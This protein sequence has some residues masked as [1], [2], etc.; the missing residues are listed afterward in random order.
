[1][2]ERLRAAL[3]FALQQLLIAASG[4]AMLWLIR[5]FTGH[6]V[7]GA[8][9][10]VGFVEALAILVVYGLHLLI[11][12]GLFRR[13][14]ADRSLGLAPSG[15]GLRDCVLGF[16]VALLLY[17]GPW[18][19][20]LAVGD[21]RITDT[22]AAHAA[23][24]SAVQVGFWVLA[25]L[26]N[27]V[28]EEATCRAFPM[29]LW[30]RERL[31]FRVLVPALAFAAFHLIDEP[32]D[33]GAF[34][35]RSSA[36]V[37]FGL[38]Y[39]TTG[40]AWLAVGLHTGLNYAS[41]ARS[42]LWHAGAWARVE[43]VPVVP[44]EVSTLAAIAIVGWIFVARN[45]LRRPETAGGGTGDPPEVPIETAQVVEAGR[46]RRRRDGSASQELRRG[47]E[48]PHR[49]AVLQRGQPKVSL[50]SAG[51][52]CVGHSSGGGEIGDRSL[53]C[54]ASVE[55]P[56]HAAAGR[57]RPSAAGDRLAL[58]RGRQHPADIRHRARRIG[59]VGGAAED[60][61]HLGVDGRMRV[62]EKN[63]TRLVGSNER[64]LDERARRHVEPIAPPGRRD[65]PPPD[66]ELDGATRGLRQ[67]EQPKRPCH[68]DR[69]SRGVESMHTVTR[70]EVRVE[71]AKAPAAVRRL[72]LHG[73]PPAR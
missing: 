35:F 69:R 66:R 39:A 59:R 73:Q 27:S 11:T 9:D 47:Y 50:E 37:L 29:Q 15:R 64:G 65:A 56:L 58:G 46:S 71:D 40:N 16:G 4:F 60:E 36:G 7:H 63:A 14:A 70:D 19:A 41:I 25:L 33:G 24:I 54:E 26:V 21:A 13:A 52:R 8:A 51:H 67:R 61:G 1:M 10:E 62:G 42:G 12:V 43:G 22:L 3:L 28:V 18:I 68:V 53:L 32:F 6:T 31:W 20:G 2:T 30:S 44:V 38:A 45:K 49:V 34:F 48:N 57:R 17:G 5:R 55:R 72:E 23:S